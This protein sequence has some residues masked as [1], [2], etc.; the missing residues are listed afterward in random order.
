MINKYCTNLYCK[1][2]KIETR[3]KISKA[4]KGKIP[5]CKGKR[6]TAGGFIWKYVIS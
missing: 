3:Q 5:W 4:N 2:C 1:E 6:Q